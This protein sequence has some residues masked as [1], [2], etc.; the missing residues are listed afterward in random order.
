[1]N[2]KLLKSYA[3][4]QKLIARK[5]KQ[6][7]KHDVSVWAS[8]G[9]PAMLCAGFDETIVPVMQQ[10][11]NMAKTRLQV[12][13]AIDASAAL[14]YDA[15]LCSDVRCDVGNLALLAQKRA[16]LRGPDLIFGINC[17]CFASSG[18]YRKWSQ[19]YPGATSFFLDLP[20]SA[21]ETISESGV[22]YIREQLVEFSRRLER[23]FH[24]EFYVDRFKAAVRRLAL[25]NELYRD[26]L[27]LGMHNPSPVCVTTFQPFLIP[28]SFYGH[29]PETT[30]YLLELK[31]ELQKVVDE[32]VEPKERI[33][34]FW[35]FTPIYRYMDDIQSVLA[36][37]DAKIVIGASLYSSFEW[38]SAAW[39]DAQEDPFH[40]QA[41][42][43]AH[44]P[45]R[46]TE[47]YKFDV[48]SRMLGDYAVDA[49]IFHASRACKANSLPMYIYREQI[50]DEF[51]LPVLLFEA[52]ILDAAVYSKSQVL[53]RLEAFLEMVEQRK[54]GGGS[55]PAHALAASRTA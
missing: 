17:V 2:A 1:M 32:P 47:K 51:G 49:V 12:R 11:Q 22:R 53:N 9:A 40:A 50:A 26:V 3:T 28:I 20:L 37:H 44:L 15:N 42:A 6:A 36:E 5:F 46:R 8:M 43:Y 55:R 54:A 4:L 45:Y 25:N 31:A 7:I 19:T 27:R 35:D 30:E 48:I 23:V 33:R 16:S 52:D 41:Y 13:Q 34:L 24:R 29:Y 10:L 14:G 21:D 38:P 18:L 39:V